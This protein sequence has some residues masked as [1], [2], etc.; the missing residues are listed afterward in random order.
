MT[1]ILFGRSP[2]GP[3]TEWHCFGTQCLKMTG[4][5]Y[6]VTTYIERYKIKMFLPKRKLP[7]LKGNTRPS[8]W[9][10]T[11][12]LEENHGIYSKTTA[13]LICNVS[14][15]V[16]RAHSVMV[17]CHTQSW[18]TLRSEGLSASLKRKRH[19]TQMEAIIFTQRDKRD[20]KQCAVYFTQGSAVLTVRMCSKYILSHTP[21]W[22]RK[23]FN[24]VPVL[25]FISLSA[26]LSGQ[27]WVLI[28][29]EFSSEFYINL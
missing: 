10:K 24:I 28:V 22:R 27:P 1:S 11:A 20:F 15:K 21:C 26:H 8:S 4:V 16:T 12:W 7:F 14:D 17:H 6:I 19:S 9:M 2:T 18:P 29:L 23:W 5:T 13:L 3:S 25:T